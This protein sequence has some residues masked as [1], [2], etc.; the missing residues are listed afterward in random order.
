[1][2]PMFWSNVAE[3]GKAGFTARDR[4]LASWRCGAPA[5]THP[6]AQHF[7]YE[8]ACDP[9]KLPFDCATGALKNP[10]LNP[11]KGKAKAIQIQIKM[12]VPKLSGGRCVLGAGEMELPSGLYVRFSC[13]DGEEIGG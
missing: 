5:I 13:G 8:T 4:L 10:G 6:D 7:S 9:A 2:E 12:L 11:G 1:C 3:H